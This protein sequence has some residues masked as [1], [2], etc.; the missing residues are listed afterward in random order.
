MLV[1]TAAFVYAGDVISRAGDLYVDG[2]LGVSTTS[3][4][5]KLEVIGNINATGGDICITGGNCLSSISG[6]VGVDTNASTECSAGEYLDGNGQC[7]NFNAT[8]QSLDTNTDTNASTECADGE[9]LDGSGQCLNFNNTVAGL[10]GNL[11]GSGQANKVAF[12]TDSGTLSSDIFFHWNDSQRRLGIGTQTPEMRVEIKNGNLLL[13]AARGVFMRDILGTPRRAYVNNA[14][15]YLIIGEP[16]ANAWSKIEY[17]TGGGRRMIVEHNNVSIN[18]S[19]FFVD[20]LNEKVGINTDSPNTALEVVGNASIDGNTFVVDDVNNRVGVGTSSPSSKLH[21]VGTETT[22]E[23]N[24]GTVD[25]V[26]DA[27]SNQRTNVIFKDAG[28]TNGVIGHDATNDRFVFAN[29]LSFLSDHIMSI[30][31]NT[32]RVGIG[33]LTPGVGSLVVNG[34]GGTVAAFTS[35]ANS[36]PSIRMDGGTDFDILSTKS[37]DIFGNNKL[38]IR[39]TTNQKNMLTIVANSGNIGIGTSS[40]TQQL[41]MQGGQFLINSTSNVMKIQEANAGLNTYIRFSDVTGADFGLVGI[42]A[43]LNTFDLYAQGLTNNL[44]L[45]AGGALAIVVNA[46]TAGE[47]EIK[48]VSGDGTGKV[49]CVKAD[50][51]LGTCSAGTI[52]SS[53]C[54]CV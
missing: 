27:S 13:D 5:E 53:S 54:T 15:Q 7:I 33:T 51:S 24:A 11:T 8:V 29:G 40:P 42:S 32:K 52:T 43:G 1:L 2:T 39:D 10:G 49:V 21:V 22:L 26:L 20:T 41:E 38:I 6:G 12:W 3:P 47:V 9:Y 31:T 14:G 36:G 30:N 46:T 37:G 35:S 23:N 28:V 50:K 25:L 34:L 48:S 17:W 44:N 19:V 4:G 18:N 45:G 16:F